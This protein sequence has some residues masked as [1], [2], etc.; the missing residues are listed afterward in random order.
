[1]PRSLVWNENFAIGQAAI[2][3]QHRRLA[4]LIN[5][6]DAAVHAGA[7]LDQLPVLLMA[8]RAA[9]DEHIQREDALL[10]EIRSGVYA[11][12]QGRPRTQHFIKALA[13]TAFDQHMA[14]HATLLPRLDEIV[15]GTLDTICD[16]LKAWFVDHAIR[17]DSYLRVILQAI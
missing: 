14:E 5:G 6:I 10:W 13:A 15:V 8:L 9:T 2:D 16:A 12:L 11:P 1:M 3:A 17:H 4:D 7:G